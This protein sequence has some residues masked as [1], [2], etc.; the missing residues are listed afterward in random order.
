MWERRSIFHLFSKCG[1]LRTQKAPNTKRNTLAL[2]NSVML[3]SYART[4][5]RVSIMGYCIKAFANVRTAKE[6]PYFRLL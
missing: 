4:D 6:Y 2:H 1:K 5:E 3:A